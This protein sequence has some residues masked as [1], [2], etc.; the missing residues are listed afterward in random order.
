MQ[1]TEGTLS[2]AGG[3][4]IYY[5]YWLPE[6]AQ[7]PQAVI[8]IVHGAAEHSGRYQHVAQRFTDSGYA[9]AAID[10][11]GH[12]QSDGEHAHVN[13]FADHIETLDI[14]QQ[15]VS[16][17]FSGLPKILLGHSMGGLIASCYLLQNQAAFA[18]CILSGPAVKTAL[19]P[20]LMQWLL[21]RLLSALVPKMGVLALDAGGVSRV[22]EEVERY[23]NDPLN[24]AGKLSARAV[25]EMFASMQ[26]IQ[27]HASDITLPLLLLH[28]G[29]DKLTSPAGSQFLYD[30]V[31]SSDKNLHI[32]PGVYHE[33]FNE[34]EKEQVFDDIEAWLSRLMS[35]A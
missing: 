34:P 1:H 23:V 30:H 3:A 13:R 26:Q 9:V 24:Y 4:S 16:A 18:G 12:G 27:S 20:P 35:P 14:F 15:Q 5:Q 25:A 22:P 19:E 31:G 8:L 28:G 29:A 33:M 21:I 7:T 10:Q 2:G 11:I 6:P 17:D 32:Y